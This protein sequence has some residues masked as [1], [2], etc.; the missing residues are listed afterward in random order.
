[1]HLYNTVM[2]DDDIVH[3]V[4]CIEYIYRLVR[5]PKLACI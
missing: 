3:P 1:M 5:N 2:L 4:E